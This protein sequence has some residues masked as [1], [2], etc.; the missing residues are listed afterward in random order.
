MFSIIFLCICCVLGMFLF[1]SSLLKF[2][3]LY[4][5]FFFAISTF[6]L[7][8]STNMINSSILVLFLLWN[9]TFEIILCLSILICDWFLLFLLIWNLNIFSLYIWLIIFHYSI[10]ENLPLLNYL[11]KSSYYPFISSCNIIIFPFVVVFFGIQVLNSIWILYLLIIL[12]VFAV[13]FQAVFYKF[14]IFQ[15]L[16]V[17]GWMF[18]LG[19]LIGKI[20]CF[21]FPILVITFYSSLT[22]G[23]FVVFYWYL[24]GASL[25][26]IVCYFS[27]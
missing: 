27:K 8:S 13:G 9:S 26:I 3:I 6:I 7:L 15:A 17:V 2:F 20:L 11:F 18:L 25:V 21:C 14:N 22:V 10:W 5:L 23:L 4:E 1:R 12:T 16:L 24:I 19:F